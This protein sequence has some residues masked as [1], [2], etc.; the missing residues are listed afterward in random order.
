MLAAL[1]PF[2]SAPLMVLVSALVWMRVCKPPDEGKVLRALDELLREDSEA[3]RGRGRGHP[4][5]FRTAEQVRV[6]GLGFGL[7]VRSGRVRL[8]RLVRAATPRGYQLRLRVFADV[9]NGCTLTRSMDVEV[10]KK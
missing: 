6:R 8:V 3:L 1:L 4:L 2:I 7:G 9:A 10:P 5:R